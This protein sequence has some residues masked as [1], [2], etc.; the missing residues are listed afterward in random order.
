MARKA[1]GAEAADAVRAAVDRTFQATVGQAQ[2]TRERAQ[3]LVDELAGAAGRV[4][5]VL[6]DLRVATGEDVRELRAGLRSLERRVSALERDSSPAV[7]RPGG[8]AK[9]KA[10]TTSRS[11]SKRGRDG[12]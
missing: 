5:S 12:S 3:E 8:A 4:R 2:M 1:P 11:T 7:K 6:E 9:R 10:A